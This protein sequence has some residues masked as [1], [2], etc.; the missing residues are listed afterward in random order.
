MLAVSFTR[1]IYT[2]EQ[3][4]KDIPFLLINAIIL[5]II[6]FTFV[7]TNQALINNQNSRIKK[8]EQMND[9][10]QTVKEVQAQF[11]NIF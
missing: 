4:K 9:E 10:L 7:Y 3:L 1:K 11:T 6:L 8:L 2:P 5:F